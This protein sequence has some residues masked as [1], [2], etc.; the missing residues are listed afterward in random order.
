MA[1]DVGLMDR[2]RE[3]GE[4]VL[5]VYSWSEPTLSFGRN[6]RTAEYDR[7]K[8]GGSKLAVVRRPTGG[9][10]ILHHHEITYSVTAPASRSGSVAADYAWIHV[11]L[12]QAL[13]N[14]GVDAEIAARGAREAPPDANP[15]FANASAGE[16]T[17]ASRKLVGS[18]QYREDGALL[19]HGSVLV[20]DDQGTIAQLAGRPPAE[21]PATLQEALGRAPQPAELLDSVAAALGEAGVEPTQLHQS[22]LWRFTVP[23]LATFADPQWTWR[24]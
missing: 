3:T 20:S 9:R 11:L 14:L 5:R 19:Q 16:I 7:G 15:C 4:A 6:Q 24:R 22:E 21:P 1:C 17:V 12:R 23:H 2:A 10:A 8:L 13:K 18:A